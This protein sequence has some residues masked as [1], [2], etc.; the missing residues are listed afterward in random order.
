[1]KKE[2]VVKQLTLSIDGFSREASAP[3][4]YFPPVLRS[5]AVRASVLLPIFTVLEK[6]CLLTNA[7]R[8]HRLDL[9]TIC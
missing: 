7:A 8:M 6:V 5:A 3:T 4:T 2:L 1:M 9:R